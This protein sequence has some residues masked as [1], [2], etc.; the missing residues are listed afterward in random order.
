MSEF[1][2]E[3]TIRVK[4]IHAFKLAKAYEN[5]KTEANKQA[6]M[7]AAH[8]VVILSRSDPVLRH[9]LAEFVKEIGAYF[10]DD[11]KI[12]LETISKVGE[13]STVSE[14]LSP[15]VD[16]GS[17]LITVYLDDLEKPVN[18]EEPVDNRE[19]KDYKVRV[20]NYS[21]PPQWDENFSLGD[22]IDDESIE[23]ED[24]DDSKSVVVHQ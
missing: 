6:A 8:N 2:C 19:R 1:W 4:M 3:E 11:V 12:K 9:K 16:S 15:N 10:D 13:S 23:D 22:C 14:E 5:D 17:Q 21:D 20:H 7:E 24:P 18:D